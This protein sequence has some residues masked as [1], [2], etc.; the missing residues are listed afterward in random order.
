VVYN[1]RPGGPDFYISLVDNT[2]NHGPGGQG[3]Y[4]LAEEADSCFAKVVKGIDVVKRMHTA[5]SKKDSFQGL[6]ENIEIVSI[7]IKT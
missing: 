3:A 5:K 1:R 4:D 2:R 7:K 6:V